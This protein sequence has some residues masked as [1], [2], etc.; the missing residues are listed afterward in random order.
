MLVKTEKL[1]DSVL[2]QLTQRELRRRLI[3][4][5]DKHNQWFLKHL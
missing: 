3:R 5:S 2:S 4:F 1:D